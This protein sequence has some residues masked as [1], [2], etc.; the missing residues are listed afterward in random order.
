MR[1]L[2]RG[3]KIITPDSEIADGSVLIEDGRIAET[4]AGDIAADAAETIDLS[5]RTLVPGFIDLHV[6]GGG[7]YSLCTRDPQ[8]ILAHR[9]WV[10]STGVTS[11]LGTVCGANLGEGSAFLKAGAEAAAVLCDGADVLG[12]N[13][14][15]PFV[16]NDRRGA[17]PR[18]W[19]SD[20]NIETFDRLNDAA[21]GA[22]RMMTVAPEVPGTGAVIDAALRAGIVV[23]VGHTDA[24]F[25]AAGESFA[26]GASHVTHAFNAMRPW[27]HREPG[28]LGAALQCPGVTVEV[29]AD[30]V[31]LHPSTVRLLVQAFGHDRIALVTDAVTSAGLESGTFRM[32]QDEARLRD[33]R[34][35]LPDG[36]IAGSAATMDTLVRNLVRWGVT[37]LPGAIRMASTVPA[38]VAGLAERKGRIAPGHDADLV[39]LDAEMKIVGTFIRGRHVFSR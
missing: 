19:P 27:H 34:M 16:S 12:L 37:D 30:G 7:G 5:G 20:P 36:T 29:I 3:A 4:R 9:R 1:T 15:G 25:E 6:H 24:T 18:T 31:H 26:A 2:L 38:G 39:V 35:A 23:S 10:T 21:G 28:P 8:E 11:L 13:L 32:G 22:L 33:G 14:E 17:L